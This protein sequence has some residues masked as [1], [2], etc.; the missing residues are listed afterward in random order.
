MD[1]VDAE[2]GVFEQVCRLGVDFEGVG[3]IEQV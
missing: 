3:V 2:V 1:V